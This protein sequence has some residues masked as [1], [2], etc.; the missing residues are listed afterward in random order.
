MDSY[1]FFQANEK[2]LDELFELGK[3]FKR[4]LRGQNLPNLSEEKIFAL[5]DKIIEKG[6]II[7]CS[8]DEKIIGSVGFFKT[9][10]W[11]S[12]NPLYN[13]QWIY[14]LPE[15]RNFTIFRN[16]INGVKKIAKDDPINLS[17]TTEFKLD[18]IL[19]KIGFTETG[20]NWRYNN[21]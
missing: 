11:Y 1:K 3:K 9:V 8:K 16:L 15:H 17:I 13:I 10:F 14:V 12:D 18:P 21:V 5:L 2:D 20:K 4:E 7:C 19:K 6:K